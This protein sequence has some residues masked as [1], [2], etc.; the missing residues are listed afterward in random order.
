MNY[1]K[2]TAMK[3]YHFVQGPA[4]FGER[5]A[6]MIYFVLVAMEQHTPYGAV[7]GICAVIMLIATPRGK[8]K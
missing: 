4:Q 2:D 8:A 1:V 6:H 3:C 5:P 7:A